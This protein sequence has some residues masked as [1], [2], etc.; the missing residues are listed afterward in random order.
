[1][2]WNG[3]DRRGNST[4]VKPKG[5]YPPSEASFAKQS[6]YRG[7]KK[8]S[9]IRGLVAGVLVCVLAV[10]AYLVFFAGSENSK[11]ERVEKESGRIKEVRPAAPR[12]QHSALSTPHSQRADHFATKS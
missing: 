12:T 8:P 6:G 11:T 7:A 2:G 4:P 5:K 10:G 3:S 1:M 9:P